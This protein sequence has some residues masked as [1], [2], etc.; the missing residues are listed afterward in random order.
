MS[1]TAKIRDAFRSGMLR[2]RSLNTQTG[3][4][5]IMIVKDVMRHSVC[6]KKAVLVT[7]SNGKSVTSTVDHS[8]I[9]Q[10]LGEYQSLNA[11]SLE[12]DDTVTSWDYVFSEVSVESVQEVPSVEYMYDLCVPGTENFVLSNGIVAHNSYSIG[13]VSLDIDKSSKYES[14]KQGAEDQFDK[15]LDLAKQTVKIIKGLQQPKYGVGIRSSFGP[16]VGKGVLSPRKFISG[17]GG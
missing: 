10:R 12:K 8:L 4:M 7:L 5:E 11:G 3:S 14:L 9:G 17:G 6:H 2:V 15:Q 1:N 13:G 16:Y